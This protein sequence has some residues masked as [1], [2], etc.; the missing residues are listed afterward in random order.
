MSILKTWNREHDFE[1]IKNSA[2]LD[3]SGQPVSGKKWM[4]YL[5]ENICVTITYK[6]GKPEL[7]EQLGIIEHSKYGLMFWDSEYQVWRPFNKSVQRTYS[8]HVAE[9]E[10]L[11]D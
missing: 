4:L 1:Y 2:E 6:T 3:K 11:N 5:S 8:N 10:L 7:V 9:R